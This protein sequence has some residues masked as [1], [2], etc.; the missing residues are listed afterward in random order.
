MTFQQTPPPEPV[1]L[2]EDS[3]FGKI[4]VS[5]GGIR[6]PVQKIVVSRDGIRYPVRE[7]MLPGEGYRYRVTL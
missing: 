6:Y 5:Q 4:K 2:S 1:F 3:P 7:M